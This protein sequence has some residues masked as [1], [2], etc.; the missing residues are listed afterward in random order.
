MDVTPNPV[1]TNNTALLASP[2]GENEEPPSTTWKSPNT[3]IPAA[4][5]PKIFEVPLEPPVSRTTRDDSASTLNA[6]TD[7]SIHTAP[8]T[9]VDY[10][11]LLGHLTYLVHRTIGLGRKVQL[12]K[13]ITVD[14]APGPYLIEESQFLPG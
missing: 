3:T 7:P 6:T 9:K 13:I 5:D 4:K 11:D 8:F 2:S 10:D 1:H 14:T 12:T